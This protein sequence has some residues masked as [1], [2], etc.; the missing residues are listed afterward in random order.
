M[1]VPDVF[2]SGVA[3]NRLSFTA[4]GEFYYRTTPPARMRP[5]AEPDGLPPPARPV[6]RVEPGLRREGLQYR[7]IVPFGEEAKFCDLIRHIAGSGQYSV[8]NVLKRFG[9]GNRDPLSFPAPGWTIA[10]DFPVKAGLGRLCDELDEG[11]LDMGVD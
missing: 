8:L 6:R 11:V 5:S 4:L 9:A 7:F 2:P 1:K 10:V 3:M